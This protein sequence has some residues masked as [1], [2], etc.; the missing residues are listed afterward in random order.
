MTEVESVQEFG[1]SSSLLRTYRNTSTNEV[2]TCAGFLELSCIKARSLSKGH[3]WIELRYI[4]I[5]VKCGPDGWW[6]RMYY[7]VVMHFRAT[8]S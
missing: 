6:G 3:V 1:P 8:A 2:C 7:V 4:P 5:E